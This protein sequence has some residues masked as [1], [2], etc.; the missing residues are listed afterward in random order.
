ME[1]DALVRFIGLADLVDTSPF[2]TWRKVDEQAGCHVVPLGGGQL[3][4]A[5]SAPR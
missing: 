5:S 2:A 4:M 1:R 3:L